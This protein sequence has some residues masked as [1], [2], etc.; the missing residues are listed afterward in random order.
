[1]SKENKNVV[2]EIK[3]LMVKFGF[4]SPED[5]KKEDYIA[6]IDGTE[7]RVEGELAEGSAIFVVTEEG[8]IPAPD[9]IH[10]LEDGTKV[11]TEGGII[12]SIEIKA[13]AEE[14]E[15]EEKI[16]V[17]AEE[18]IK[19]EIEEK[20]EEL[21]EE[22]KEEVKEEIVEKLEEVIEEKEEVELEEESKEDAA[23]KIIEVIVPILEK[24]KDLE[25]ELKKVK[26]SFQSFKNEPAGKAVNKSKKDFSRATDI[27]VERILQM[28]NNR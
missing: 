9:A 8:D 11:E 19:E 18:E 12:K 4:M 27:V 22:I 23:D 24:V 14:I 13:E 21:E 26:A 1:M 7:I 20:K 3:N 25:E 6:L 28:K 15:E 10:E 16:E 17:E 2:S 5:K